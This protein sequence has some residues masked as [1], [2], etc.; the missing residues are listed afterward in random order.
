MKSL[1]VLLFSVAGFAFGLNAQS[2]GKFTTETFTVYGNCGMC[3]DRIETALKVKGVKKAS[4][5]ADAEKLTV[6][7]NKNILSLDQIHNKVAAIG[8]DTDKVKA[9]DKVY[10]KLH[11]CCQYDRKS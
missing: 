7:F 11:G 5:N 4:W 6:T 8:H 9:D 2:T 3:K 1:I 10:S